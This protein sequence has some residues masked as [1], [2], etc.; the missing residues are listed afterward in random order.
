MT[1]YIVVLCGKNV[2]LVQSGEFETNVEVFIS[3]IDVL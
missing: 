1:H 3:A 2:V